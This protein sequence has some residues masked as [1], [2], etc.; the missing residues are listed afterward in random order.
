MS[1][2]VPRRD[3]APTRPASFT[4]RRYTVNEIAETFE[5]SRKTIYRHL[6]KDGPRRQPDKTTRQQRITR[7]TGAVPPP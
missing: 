5:V 3:T 2:P 6:A 7:P 1:C 4:K